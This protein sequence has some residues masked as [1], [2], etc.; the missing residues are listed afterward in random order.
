MCIRD[1][2]FQARMHVRERLVLHRSEYRPPILRVRCSERPQM[3]TLEGVAAMGDGVELIEPRIVGGAI[4]RR[5][6][7]DLGA[8]D[9]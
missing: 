1:S 2:P 3:L 9:M 7:G 8:E 4:H 6:D 5:S